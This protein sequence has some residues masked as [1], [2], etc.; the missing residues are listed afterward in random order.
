MPTS[1]PGN[2]AAPAASGRWRAHGCAE[3][4]F[5]LLELLIVLAIV[6]VA[7]GLVSAA[8]PDSA[9]ARLD[10]EG[11]RLAVLLE[12]A[13]SEARVSG[14]VVRWVPRSANEVAG[15]AGAS[16]GGAPGHFRFMGTAAARALPTRWLDDRVAAQVVGGTFVLLGPEAILPAQRVVLSLGQRQLEV[17]S[18]GLAPFAP[19]RGDSPSPGG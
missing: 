18:D 13:R 3:R 4:G 2:S 6:A 7:V 8:L 19:V 10:E 5:T 9:A 16:S 12:A 15:D 17:A 1:D 14:T 11:E